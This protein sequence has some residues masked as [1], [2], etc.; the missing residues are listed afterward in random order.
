TP[1][2]P[3][4]I[5]SKIIAGLMRELEDF[6]KVADRYFALL[7]ECTSDPLMGRSKSVINEKIRRLGL[8]DKTPRP[9]FSQ[10]LRKYDLED[11]FASKQ[12]S[13]DI[14]GLS[15]GLSDAQ[16]VSK[17]LIQTFSGMRDEESTELP[18]HCLITTVS[19]G[20]THYVLAGRTTKLN[21]GLF[22]RAKWATSREGQ[23][24]VLLA[25][26]IATAIYES[27]GETPEPD[28][29]RINTYPL[30]V[31]T[32]YLPSSGQRIDKGH[33]GYLA[34][35]CRMADNRKL[36]LRI[37]PKIEET[38]LHELE[39]IDPHR[40]WR[41]EDKFQ[42]NCEWPL[43]THQLRRSLALYAQRSGLVSLPSLR[44]QL[45]HITEEMSRYYARG[46]AY[47]KN[48]IGDDP[49]HFGLEWQETTPVSAALSFLLNVL[50]SDEVLF[51]GYVNW[52]ERNLK[53]A[54][55]T[56]C[57]DRET[58]MRRFKRG[59]LTYRETSLGG[60]TNVNEC[61][62]VAIKWLDIECIGNCSNLVGKLS[63]LEEVILA[64]ENWVTTLDPKSIEYRTEKEDL[65]VLVAARGKA[66]ERQGMRGG[67][68]T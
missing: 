9:P 35:G 5:Y 36:M 63:K 38:D 16:M 58:T 29:D 7:T 15:S 31:S 42:V 23:K 43:T 41:F 32:A 33:R 6:E 65:A 8:A 27:I 61:K 21:D 56:V 34:G 53:S 26:R 55:G 62:Q 20:R 13:C 67:I 47:A 44:R 30:F 68:A 12:L 50:H 64:Q 37:L 48:F 11:Y 2:I 40:A 19:D 60:C 49:D 39:Q 25:Q 46:S 24:A 45:Q 18:F 52:M 22:K 51:G 57:V 1:P 17:L 3:T 4:R 28:E 14:N 66:L 54:D 10:L 59:E